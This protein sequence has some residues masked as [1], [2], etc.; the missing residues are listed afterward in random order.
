[1]RGFTAAWLLG[2]G[3]VT[4]RQVH[5]SH[6]PPVP[7]TLAG[8][9]GLFAALATLGDVFPA[10]Q[11][12]ITLLAFG[13]DIAGLLNVLPAGLMGQITTAGNSQQAGTGAADEGGT[14]IS[15][16]IRNGVQAV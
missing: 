5:A 13:L 8:V 12:T 10:S 4:W 11:R 9:T 16:V 3:I 7:G 14:G 2:L 15:P 6:R 1:M